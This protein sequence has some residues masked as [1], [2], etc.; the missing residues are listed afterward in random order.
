YVNHAGLIQTAEWGIRPVEGAHV[1]G[2]TFSD[3]L[4][5]K[6][7]YQASAVLSEL[8]GVVPYF[9]RAAG[10]VPE[11]GLDL[12]AGQEKHPRTTALGTVT[13]PLPTFRSIASEML[14]VEETRG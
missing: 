13:H 8:G 6:G 5:R 7:L 10:G 9:A 2:Q 11:A 1:D 12:V 4:A 14:E 3:L